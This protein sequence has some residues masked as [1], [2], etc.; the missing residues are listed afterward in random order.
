MAV[1]E[2]KNPSSL[3]VKFDCG[4][5]D[6]GKTIVRTRTYPNVKAGANVQNVFDVANALVDLQQHS[7]L[8]VLKQ[9]NTLLN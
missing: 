3:K 1:T 6:D 5:N 8:E 4:L 9:D 2:T 7:A